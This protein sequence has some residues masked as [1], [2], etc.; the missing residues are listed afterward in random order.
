M[1]KFYFELFENNISK[2]ELK[3]NK[4]NIYVK[5]FKLKGYLLII[6]LIVP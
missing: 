5:L 3:K 6:F 2:L 4:K 1:K